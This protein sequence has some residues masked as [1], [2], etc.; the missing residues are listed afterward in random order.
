MILRL[1][2]LA[3]LSAVFGAAVSSVYGYVFASNLT[4]FGKFAP[5]FGYTIAFNL[6]MTLGAAIAFFA[7]HKVTKRFYLTDFLVSFGLAVVCVILTLMTSL[8]EFPDFS[9]NMDLEIMSFMYFALVMPLIYFPVLSWFAFK[10]LFL[11]KD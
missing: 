2:I 9:G 8:N 11:K 4:D 5:S 6:F 3:L 1:F 10:P 7:I